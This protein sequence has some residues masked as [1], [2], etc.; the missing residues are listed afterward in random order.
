MIYNGC[1]LLATLFA[2][3]SFSQKIEWGNE[4]KSNRASG[5]TQTLGWHDD[6]LS[7]LEEDASSSVSIGGN[8]LNH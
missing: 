5:Q 6:I 1:L 4:S 8:F 3:S 2:L 7:T